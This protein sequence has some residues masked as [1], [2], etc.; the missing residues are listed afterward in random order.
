MTTAPSGLTLTRDLLAFDTVS[1]PG[2]ERPCVEHIAGLLKPAG[3]DLAF[4]EFAPGRPSLVATLPADGPAD[5]APIAYS[6]HV[7]TVPLG[8][9]PWSVD[10]FAGEVR[11]G[12]LYGRGSSDMKSGVAACVLAGLALSQ[13]SGR[14]ADVVLVISAGEETGCEGV[15]HLARTPGALPQLGAL[16]VAEPTDNRPMVGHKG[17]L[18]LTLGF[19]GVTAHGSMPEKGDNAIFKACAAVTKLQQFAFGVS[20]HPVM[21]GL[22]LNVG[23]MSAGLN[24]NSVPD[25]AEIGVD[26]RTVVGQTNAEARMQLDAVLEGAA[27]FTTLTDMDHVYTDP[28]TPWMQRAFELWAQDFGR[29][30]SVET[31]TYF[32]DASV[33]KPA[34]GNPPT[35]IMGPGP[36]AMA[37]QTDEYCDVDAIDACTDYFV[38]LGLDH[39]A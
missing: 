5:R 4:H 38:R 13:R 33:L 26:I 21:G 1:P 3:F 36:M 22:S 23:T 32:T 6:G 25:S 9:A 8:R 35:L 27:R 19:E 15:M 37:H 31:A 17:A 16:V 7:D 30:P 29:S 24:I 18:W 14:R 20:P 39:V 28:E 2:N 34:C 10:P 12:R 11:D